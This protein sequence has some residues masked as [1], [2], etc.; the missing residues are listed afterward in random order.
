MSGH[1]VE[2]GAGVRIQGLMWK[3]GLEKLGNIVDLVSFWNAYDWR[4]YDAI[5][6]LQH[7]G[8]F[9]NMAKLISR[10]NDKIA[11]APIID[12][13]TT[14]L[15]TRLL[16]KWIRFSRY[17]LLSDENNLYDGCKYGKIFLTRSNEETDYLS[18]CCEIP[19]SK[20]FQIPLSVRFEKEQLDFSK[21][22]DFCFHTSR[23]YSGNK[24]VTRLVAAAK[25]YKFKLVLAGTLHGQYEKDWLDNLIADSTN[26]KY[27]GALSDIELVK[28]YK[29]AKVFALPSLVEGVG[30]VSMEAALY[31]CEI[32]LTNI[33]APKEYWDNKALLVDPYSIDSIGKAVVECMKYG[34][35]Q[36]ELIHFIYDNYSLSSCSRKLEKALASMKG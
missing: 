9:S 7:I 19:K 24:N 14:K 15:K 3:E 29:K 6:I 5:I 11:I 12:P 16:A 23:L 4:S 28:T 17:G 21:K 13:S 2:P 1:A 18:Y 8:L 32:V 27:V 33:G 34:H 35:S 30:M 31:G 22:E 20:I 25:K 10:I 36:P 26:I